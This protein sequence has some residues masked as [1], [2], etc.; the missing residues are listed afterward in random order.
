M[1]VAKQTAKN[2]VQWRAVVE[3]LCILSNIYTLTDRIA[4][5]HYNVKKNMAAIVINFY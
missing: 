4:N 3:A 5:L 1:G 2:N